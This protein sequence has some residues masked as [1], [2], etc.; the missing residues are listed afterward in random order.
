MD[1]SRIFEGVRHG[2]V[3]VHFQELSKADRQYIS[4]EL[5]LLTLSRQLDG[6]SAGVLDIVIHGIKT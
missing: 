2:V 6:H 4:A 3:Q 5:P 1:E